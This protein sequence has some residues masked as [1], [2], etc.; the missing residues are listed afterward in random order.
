MTKKTLLNSIEVTIN[1]TI[2]RLTQIEGYNKMS[3]HI[4]FRE[5]IEAIEE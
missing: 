1:S 3:I 4:E 5:W 2:K